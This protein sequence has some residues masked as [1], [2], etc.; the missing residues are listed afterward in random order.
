MTPLIDITSWKNHKILRWFRTN[1]RRYIGY[2]RHWARTVNP[3]D[4]TRFY[5]EGY[6]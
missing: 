1:H 6:V 3:A 4:M 5:W 2:M